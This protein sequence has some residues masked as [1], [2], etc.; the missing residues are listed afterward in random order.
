MNHGSN[1][2]TSNSEKI[3]KVGY[4]VLRLNSKRAHSIKFRSGNLVYIKIKNYHSGRELDK[5]T[6]IQNMVWKKRLVQKE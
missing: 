3:F 6:E 2:K 4:I 5:R 1:C